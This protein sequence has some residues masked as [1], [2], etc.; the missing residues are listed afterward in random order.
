MSHIYGVCREICLDNYNQQIF[1]V[2]YIIMIVVNKNIFI[3]F[4][5]FSTLVDRH[6]LNISLG[7]QKLFS[8]KEISDRFMAY[9]SENEFWKRFAGSQF[10][11]L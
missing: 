2:F 7:V 9:F 1:A 11:G 4:H 8:P 10:A 5:A 6:P 3:T